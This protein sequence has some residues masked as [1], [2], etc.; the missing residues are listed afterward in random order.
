VSDTVQLAPQYSPGEVEGPRYA[1]WE[2]AGYFTADPER[3]MHVPNRVVTE[4][5]DRF[6]VD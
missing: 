2:K 1:L 3:E 4:N 6:A 5:T